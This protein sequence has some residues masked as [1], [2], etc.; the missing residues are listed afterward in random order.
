MNRPARQF[1]ALATVAGVALTLGAATATASATA[2][3]HAAEAPATTKSARALELRRSLDRLVAAGA[4]GAVALVREHGHTTR[5]AAGY[6][7]TR[8]KAR[9]RPSDR[10]RVGSVTKTFVATVILQLAGEGKLSLEDSVER[11][12]P[13]EVPNGATITVRQLL[14]M[15]SGIFDYLDDGDD[16][17]LTREIADPTVR[18]TPRELVAIA[19]A[20]AP[21]FAPG[22][23]WS[24]S[25]TGYILLG[26]IAEQAAQRPIA[27][28]L[29]ERIFVPAGLHATSLES[30]P[31]IAGRHAHGYDALRGKTVHD[32]SNLD[33]TWAWTAGAIVSNADDLARFYRVLL[34]GRLLRPDL[35]AT[36]Q[37]TVPM[38]GG[39]PRGYA[40][41]TG[42][43]TLP[44]PCGLAWGHDG[45]TP[46]YLTSVLN[47]RNASRQVI[48]LLNAGET[49]LGDQT[50]GPARDL[51]TTAYC[52]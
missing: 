24:Y 28:S 25:N 43:S 46:G 29:R 31:R 16:T 36:M 45:S 44:M 42:I 5:L 9:M 14:T 23:A 49:A 26:Q 8:T 11:W 51:L 18:W 2:N 52:G 50:A 34:Q 3:P 19:T 38:G 7:D 21:R 40:Y 39:A 22:S 1:A 15:T 27:D 47:S 20:H 30:G 4:P 41:G 13:G 17:V 10:F 33:Q 12:L 37:T 6:A 48:I 32:L 35:L